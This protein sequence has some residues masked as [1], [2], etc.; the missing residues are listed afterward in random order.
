MINLNKNTFVLGLS[1]TVPCW[2]LAH[3]SEGTFR[4]IMSIHKYFMHSFIWMAY[5]PLVAIVSSWVEQPFIVMIS[6]SLQPIVTSTMTWQ[7]AEAT[8]SVSVNQPVAGLRAGGPALTKLLN[9]CISKK[10]WLLGSIC[11]LNTLPLAKQESRWFLFASSG[12]AALQ[13]YPG[14]SMDRRLCQSFTSRT[15]AKEMRV[16][17]RALASL[18]SGEGSYLGSTFTGTPL[19]TEKN[20]DL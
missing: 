2:I 14:Y 16:C 3:V 17:M 5:A 15:T 19:I 4:S 6:Y 8:N 1:V 12:A 10:T 18:V 20:Y 13:W 7:T 11:V 9:I